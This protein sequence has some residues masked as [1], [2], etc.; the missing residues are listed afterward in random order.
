MDVSRMTDREL[1]QALQWVSGLEQ[2]TREL[3]KDDDQAERDQ[4]LLVARL[5][6]P[7]RQKIETWI[8]VR[9]LRAH[10]STPAAA[11]AGNVVLDRS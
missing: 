1:A 5:A 7:L 3:L 4:A 11:A 6:T 8:S 10:L 9:A 2:R